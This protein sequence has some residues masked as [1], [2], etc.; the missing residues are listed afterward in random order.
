MKN[1]SNHFKTNSEE[2]FTIVEVLTSLVVIGVFIT[3]IFQLF[4]FQSGIGA[5]WLRFELA[6]Q[7]AYNNMNKYGRYEAAQT[8]TCA[9]Y[10]TSSSSKTLFS[11]SAPVSGLPSPV[12]QQVVSSMPYGCDATKL[13]NRYPI[14][15]ISTVT[16]GPDSK[17]ITHATY[18][19]A[20][21]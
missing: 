4:I 3:I 20:G 18:V 1:A 13:S 19:N 12:S 14:K 2:G 21:S 10:P 7:L 6:E 5:S 15:I 17:Q 9:D 16:Y 11:Q 8:T